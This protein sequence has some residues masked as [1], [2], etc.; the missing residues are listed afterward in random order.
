MTA[1][2]WNIANLERELHDGYVY[3]AHWTVSLVD[4]DHSASAYGSIGLER[5]ET[6]LISFED[7]TEE[8]VISWIH[9]KMGEEKVESIISS[10]TAQVQEQKT[11]SKLSGVPW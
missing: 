4:G 2:T 7:L 11:P 5:P 3:I 9:D 1:T 10:L 8:L 6:D